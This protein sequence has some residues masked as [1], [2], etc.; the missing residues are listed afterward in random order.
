MTKTKHKT[1][2]KLVYQ[3]ARHL[4][5]KGRLCKGCIDKMEDDVYNYICKMAWA[6]D[7]MKYHK[8]IKK[9]KDCKNALSEIE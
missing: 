6:I 9:C 5:P 7:R 3:I 4:I 2:R 8:E 1:I